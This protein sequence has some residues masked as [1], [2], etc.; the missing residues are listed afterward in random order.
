[1]RDRIEANSDISEEE[2]KKLALKSI[3]IRKYTD[4]RK[5]KK[6]VFVPEKLINIV[7]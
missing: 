7:V 2:A 4:N 1:M 6:V 3:K 5:I